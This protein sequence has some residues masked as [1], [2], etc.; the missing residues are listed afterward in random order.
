VARIAEAVVG[1]AAVLEDGSLQAMVRV[2]VASFSIGDANTQNCARNSGKCVLGAVVAGTY[3][4]AEIRIKAPGQ[5]EQQPGGSRQ[6]AATGTLTL[7]G[8]SRKI[9]VIVKVSRAIGEG[10]T[11]TGDLPVDLNEFKSEE[12]VRMGLPNES[13]IWIHFSVNAVPNLFIAGV[14][15]A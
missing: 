9:E 1:S 12:L 7:G 3:H 2:P 4:F 11:L 14:P 13:R 5:L 8:M 10:I 15:V 6:V